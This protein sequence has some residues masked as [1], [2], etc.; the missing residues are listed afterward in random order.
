MCV[1]YG[2][3]TIVANHIVALSGAAFKENRTPRMT[4]TDNAGQAPREHINATG[5]AMGMTRA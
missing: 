2:W 4:L 3:P 5:R 1:Q